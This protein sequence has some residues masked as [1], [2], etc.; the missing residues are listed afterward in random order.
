MTEE[1]LAAERALQHEDRVAVDAATAARGS[2]GLGGVL[3]WLA[4]GIPFLIGLFI[5]LQKA[6]ALV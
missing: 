6:V 1:E 5:A 2:F 3:A 4:V